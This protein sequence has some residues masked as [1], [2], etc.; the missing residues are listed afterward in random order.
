MDSEAAADERSLS[1]DELAETED[2]TVGGAGR[3]KQTNMANIKMGIMK[4]AGSMFS[5]SNVCKHYII[6]PCTWGLIWDCSVCS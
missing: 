5:D 3:R 1:G 2:R 6:M 4:F